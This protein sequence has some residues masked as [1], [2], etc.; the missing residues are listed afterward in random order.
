MSVSITLPDDLEQFSQR[1]ARLMGVPVET[2]LACT[3]VERW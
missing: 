2:L 3:I 1:Q